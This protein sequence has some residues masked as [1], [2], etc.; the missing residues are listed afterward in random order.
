MTLLLKMV[1]HSIFQYLLLTNSL[2]GH[3]NSGKFSYKDASGYD[4][5]SQTLVF[6]VKF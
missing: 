5:D 1:S 6:K 3:M 4:L 2:T